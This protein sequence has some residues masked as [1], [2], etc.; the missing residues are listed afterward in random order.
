MDNFTENSY[1]LRI[2]PSILGHSW[3][4]WGSY[5]SIVRFL[6]DHCLSCCPLF[7]WSLYRLFF[8]VGHCIVCS[9]VFHGFWVCIVCPF[10]LHGFWVC[11]VCPVVLHGFWVYR[12]SCCASRL[13]SLYRL[14]FCA[15]R[16]LS[17]PLVSLNFTSI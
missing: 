2:Q 1:S 13:L 15:S 17:T 5:C 3:V 9:F 12:L 16:L 7:F 10:V 6:L 11:I 14:F 4:L 8:S